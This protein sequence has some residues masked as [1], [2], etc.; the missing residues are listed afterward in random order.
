MY[1][2]EGI[3]TKLVKLSR[4]GGNS[5]GRVTIYMYTHTCSH[6]NKVSYILVCAFHI[7]YDEMKLDTNVGRWAVHVIELSRTKRHLDRAALMVFWEKLDK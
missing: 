6:Y 5:R 4:C 1:F 3:I 2:R 7:K